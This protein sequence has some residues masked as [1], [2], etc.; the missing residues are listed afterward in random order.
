MTILDSLS[1]AILF[2]SSSHVFAAAFCWT[3]QRPSPTMPP[4][5]LFRNDMNS[6]ARGGG[7]GGDSLAA[8]SSTSDNVVSDGGGEGE[9]T[10]TATSN[11]QLFQFYNMANGM[12][13]YAGTTD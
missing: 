2:L 4:R 12:C 6:L 7:R 11:K 9:G 13:P 3:R 5:L 1:V 8:S 10:P